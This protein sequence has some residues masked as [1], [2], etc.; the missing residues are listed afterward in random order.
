MMQNLFV[1]PGISSPDADLGETNTAYLRL[2]THGRLKPRLR[3]GGF[4][5]RLPIIL[6]VWRV[7]TLAYLVSAG[8]AFPA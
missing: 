3:G 1:V 2:C 5:M 4:A 6:S 7:A 8:Y